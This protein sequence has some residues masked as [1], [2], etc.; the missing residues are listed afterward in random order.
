MSYSEFFKALGISAAD[1][2]A[3][4]RFADASGVPVERLWHYNGSNAVPS[5]CDLDKVCSA[6]GVSPIELM[7]KMGVLDRRII[8]A[9]KSKAE[10]VFALIQDD[11]ERPRGRTEPQPAVFQTKL[12]R[13]YQGDCLAVMQSMGS[14]TVDLI[15]ADPPFNLK[16]LYPSGVDD[17]LKEARYLE[18]CENWAAECARLLKPG[19]SLF[20]WNLPKWNTHISAYLN[21]RL[22]F[23]HWIGVDIKYSLPIPGRLYPSHYSLLYYCKGQKPNTF[24]PDRL[25]MEVCPAC[26]ADLRDY[27]GYKDKM[28]P[29]GVNMTDVWMDIAP[30]RH[31]KYKK[32]K[33]SNELS[34]KLLDR[35]I[36]MASEEGDVVFDPFGGSGTTYMVAE[37]KKRRWI[38]IELGPVDDIERRFREIDSEADYIEKIRRNYNSLFT[39]ETLGIRR[40]LGLWTCE[41]VR[42]TNRGAH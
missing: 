28:N 1:R 7:L 19:G 15:F 6:S 16:K 3:V 14:D 41:S 33:G 22:T 36:Q 29:L 40:Q 35:I 23:R 25:P 5:G 30:V 24:H 39:E 42:K 20:F 17:D 2:F 37:I 10:D 13:L 34:V 18:W 12:G 38:G 27:G 32:R 9:L 8:K 4:K 26:R 21:G 31:S 11:V